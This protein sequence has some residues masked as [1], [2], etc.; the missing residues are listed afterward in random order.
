MGGMVVGDFNGDGIPDAVTVGESGVWFFAGQGGGVF[1]SGVLTPVTALYGGIVAA[2]FNGDGKLDLA[3]PILNDNSPYADG[4]VVLFG[5]GD[6]T[7]LTPVLYRGGPRGP[8]FLA[9]RRSEPGWIRGHCQ[10]A[11]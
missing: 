4:F 8:H 5:N 10:R 7:S 9:K 2:D 11:R 1:S 6:G 3:V